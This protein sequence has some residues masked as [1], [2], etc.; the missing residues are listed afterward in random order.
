MQMGGLHIS[1]H[2][3]ALIQMLHRVKYQFYNVDKVEGMP[4]KSSEQNPAQAASFE[5]ALAELEQL[6]ATMESGSLSLDA[7]MAA[8]QRGTELVK[9]CAAQLQAAQDQLKVLEGDTLKSL[10]LEP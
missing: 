9:Q 4:A 10:K 1:A 5:A 6:V 7:S 3:A 2:V 8:Y